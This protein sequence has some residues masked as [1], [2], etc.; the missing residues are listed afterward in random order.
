MLDHD[1][2]SQF[3]EAVMEEVQTIPQEIQEID[4]KDRVDLTGEIIVTIDGDDSKDFDDAVSV[5]PVE[6][7]W[8]LKLSLI[9]I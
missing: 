5:T 3:P 8:V 6:N 2:D 7:G 4:K 1:I 9:H